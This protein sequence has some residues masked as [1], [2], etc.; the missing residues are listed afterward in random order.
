MVKNYKIFIICF[1]FILLTSL[2]VSN[3][4]ATNYNEN[5]IEIEYNDK[6]IVFPTTLENLNCKFTDYNYVLSYCN[7][8][9]YW[10]NFCMAESI[11]KCMHVPYSFMGDL[12]H[13]V[14][15]KNKSGENLTEYRY[16]FENN[17]WVCRDNGTDGLVR[18][19]VVDYILSNNDIYNENNTIFFQKTPLFKGVQ[20]VEITQVEEIPKAITETMKTII[21]I[22]LVGLSIFLM[23]YLI[24]LVISRA[25]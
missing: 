9:K 19:S 25:I 22:G 6:V 16:Y 21:P 20:V 8:G 4:Y 10:L 12:Y 13:R 14:L 11:E 15:F 3:V 1:L 7:D 24:Q 5:S 18:N 17:K 23:I 2:C